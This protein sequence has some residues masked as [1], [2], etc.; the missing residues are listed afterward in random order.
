MSTN[1]FYLAPP[2]PPLVA[3]APP[4]PT[5]RL[6]LRAFAFWCRLRVTARELRDVFRRCGRP[7]T[8]ADAFLDG[9]ADLLLAL[10][11]VRTTPARVIDLAAAR[12]RLRP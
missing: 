3:S 11:P 10:R 9:P 5:L 2:A 6:R 4:S 1:V 7:Q 12:A 8:D